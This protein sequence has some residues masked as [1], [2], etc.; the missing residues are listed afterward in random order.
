LRSVGSSALS[1]LSIATVLS[2]CGTAARIDVRPDVGRQAAVPDAH[3]VKAS[4]EGFLRERG[5]ALGS[6]SKH[7]SVRD[8]VAYMKALPPTNGIS[9]V[10]IWYKNFGSRTLGFEVEIQLQSIPQGFG[11]TVYSQGPNGGSEVR[12]E[13]DALKEFLNAAFPGREIKLQVWRTGPP[14]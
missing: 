14:A 7:K 10:E 5:Y 6:D 9:T 8:H 12:H 4:L 1:V 11:V 13:A 3:E 2:G